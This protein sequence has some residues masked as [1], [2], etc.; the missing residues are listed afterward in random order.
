MIIRT[1]AV[2][3][4]QPDAQFLPFM[5]P[6]VIVFTLVGAL[7]AVIVFALVGRFARRPISLFRRIALVTLLVSFIPDILMAIT[8]FNPGTTT[9][10]VVVL[11]LMHVAS[12]AICVGML[13]RL[14][15]A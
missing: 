15:R 11:M 2:A 7:G 14:A 3:V 10:N 8:K 13:T 4:L 12:W 6:V 5:L 9:A 1:I